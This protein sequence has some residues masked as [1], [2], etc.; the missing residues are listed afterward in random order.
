M[1]TG[2]MSHLGPVTA[3]HLGQMLGLAASDVEKAL[4]RME[5]GGI[6]LRGNFTGAASR[7]AAP[8]AT[9]DCRAPLDRTSGGG[10]PQHPRT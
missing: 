1:V 10:S 7:A 8:R 4:L 5:A 6:V 3:S 2:W 9:G